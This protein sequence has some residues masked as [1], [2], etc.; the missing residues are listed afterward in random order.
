MTQ[1]LSLL[2]ADLP[3]CRDDRGRHQAGDH[4]RERDREHQ[5]RGRGPADRRKG[6]REGRNPRRGRAAAELA[7]PGL[8]PEPELDRGGADRRNRHAH[9]GHN[10]LQR[11]GECQCRDQRREHEADSGAV[12]TRSAASSPEIVNQA[13]PPESWP[14]AITTTGVISTMAVELS[15]KLRHSI[16]AGGTRYNSCISDCDTSQ[17]SRRSNANS[18]QRSACCREPVRNAVAREPCWVGVAFAETRIAVSANW[19]EKIAITTPSSIRPKASRSSR[20]SPSPSVARAG[21]Q[22]MLSAPGA[23]AAAASE[24]RTAKR[25]SVP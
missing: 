13:R 19:R 23:Q 8:Y 25:D 21:H 14:A 17:G 24:V 4:G 6:F 15:A 1:R 9:G 7:A 16:S 22:T 12:A 10:G 5:R 2:W 20:A 3:G 11:R 18:F